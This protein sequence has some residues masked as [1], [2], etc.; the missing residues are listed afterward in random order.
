MRF[1]YWH[2]R[3]EQAV[4]IALEQKQVLKMVMTKELRQAIELLQFSTYDLLQFIQRQAEENPLIE[5]VEKDEYPYQHYE[6]R[7]Y[8][9]SDEHFDPITI[10]ASKERSLYEHLLEQIIAHQLT[11]EQYEL[12]KYLIYN[13]DAKGYLTI[14]DEEVSELMN[15][16]IEE[17]MK[18]REIITQLEPAG[19]G[20]RDLRECLLIQAKR[21]YPEDFVLSTIIDEYLETLANKQWEKIAEHLNISLEQVKAVYQTIQ[22]LD[23]R[24]ASNFSVEANNYVEPDIVIEADPDKDSYFISLNDRFLPEIRF[25]NIYSN[26]VKDLEIEKFVKDCYQKYQ[27]LRN[28]IEQRRET[29]LKIMKVIVQ[30]QHDF[31]KEGFRSLQPL[32]LREVAEE[33]GMHE[34]TVSRAT[35]N[36][37]VQTPL[38]VFELRK[39]FS[40]KLATNSGEETSQTQ[41]KI[42]L[43]QIID[44][45]DKYRPL[46]DQKIADILNEEKGIIISRRTVAKYR[47]E[48]KIPAS[49]R[50]KKIKM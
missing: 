10:A 49:S 32:T 42:L 30:R 47:D 38:G 28:S 44:E 4:R 21:K 35:A 46:S 34:S 39:L 40:T 8:R 12:V 14:E 6:S 3:G 25:N 50:R 43:K 1:L 36:K 19:V 37:V 16:S 22:T 20:A 23:P 9:S 45:E 17:V 7:R 5:L 31:L 15:V 29:I 11:D 41:V 2:E 18:A 27:W 48:L 26:Y 33:I 24:P 13:I